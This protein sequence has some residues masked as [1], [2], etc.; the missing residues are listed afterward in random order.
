[1]KLRETASLTGLLAVLLLI[2]FPAQ[3]AAL[4]T[5]QAKADFLHGLWHPLGGLDHVLTMVGVGV[6]AALVLNRKRLVW[7]LVFTLVMFM[8][9]WARFLGVV[10]P[11]VET[12]IL[13]S[14]IVVGLL[15]AFA[16]RLPVVV[17]ALIVGVFA[18]FHGAAHAN[19]ASAGSLLIYAAGFS[20]STF[21]LGLAGLGLGSLTEWNSGRMILRGLGA[22]TALFGLYLMFVA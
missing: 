22:A 5:G 18:V 9:F 4:T 8:A 3:A 19:E 16:L 12:G 7:P 17:G 2:A 1:M 13:A 11:F 15:V 14:V 10:V 20:V 21:A 6:W